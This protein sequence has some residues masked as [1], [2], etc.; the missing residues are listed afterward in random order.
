MFTSKPFIQCYMLLI[1]GAFACW[2]VALLVYHLFGKNSK[3]L[4]VGGY[5][6]WVTSLVLYA[7]AVVV[8]VFL[9][10]HSGN[11]EIWFSDFGQ[12]LKYHWPHMILLFVLIVFAVKLYNRAKAAAAA[13]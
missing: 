4:Q 6:A 9:A 1:F 13:G 8:A 7:V 10:S 12:F 11:R 3:K 2:L 5:R